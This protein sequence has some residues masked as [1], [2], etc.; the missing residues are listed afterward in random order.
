M[1]QKYMG[2][3]KLTKEQLDTEVKNIV[4][5]LD[6]RSL[7]EVT[8]FVRGWVKAPGIDEAYVSS[9]TGL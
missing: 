3:S 2:Q 1:K 5:K 6:H 9:L 8:E 7:A 4:R